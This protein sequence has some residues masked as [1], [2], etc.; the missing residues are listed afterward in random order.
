[1][2]VLIV[3]GSGLIGSAVA[4]ALTR[5][6]EVTLFD[7]QE[8]ASRA[9]DWIRG[10]GLD[11][12]AC[13]AAVKGQDWI[14][15]KAGLMGGLPSFDKPL[16]YHDINVRIAL[17]FLITAAESGVKRVVFDSSE[18][19]FGPE[20]NSP[21]GE[22]ELPRP[23][24]V[25]GCNKFLVECYLKTFQKRH[26]LDWVILRYPRVMSPK[27]ENLLTRIHS[28]IVRTQ[29][30]PVINEGR[31]VIDMIHWE[32]VVKIHELVL[33]KDSTNITL[34]VGPGEGQTV[35]QIIEWC[36]ED[37][38]IPC[39]LENTFPS[40]EEVRSEMDLYH[41]SMVLSNNL[42]QRLFGWRPRSVR[43][44]VKDIVETLRRF[45]DNHPTM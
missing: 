25:Y 17:N 45:H 42:T 22:R 30:C 38:G 43:S 29:K 11:L 21:H 33:E 4:S 14:F 41:P 37:I 40:S 19:V 7:L 28:S 35:R 31:A 6:H 24:S 44:T 32:D 12:A 18:T 15:L 2:R 34:H 9:V 20:N 26:G 36:A 27:G 1:M 13:R 16:L 3:G 5:C 39:V 10:N 8:P 23:Q